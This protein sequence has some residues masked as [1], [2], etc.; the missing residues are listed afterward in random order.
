MAN[1]PTFVE[2]Y[3]TGKDAMF[4][5]DGDDLIIMDADD[6]FENLDGGAGWDRVVYLGFEVRVEMT[7]AADGAPFSAQ[8]T[9]G[10]AESL[11]LRGGDVVYVRAT[12][13][14][15]RPGWG[16]GGGVHSLAR[17]NHEI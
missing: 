12:R 13:S 8:I 6:K 4:G 16:S 11:L 17:V 15:E 1:E 5:G 9:R 7:N 10:D 14:P 3:L 2:K